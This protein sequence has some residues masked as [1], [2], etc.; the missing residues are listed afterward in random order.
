M[1]KDHRGFNLAGISPASKPTGG[2]IT[3][4]DWESSS[5][6]G[7][8]AAL[9]NRPHESIPFVWGRVGNLRRIGNPP[10][11]DMPMVL[12]VDESPSKR[13]D[14]RGRTDRIRNE[15]RPERCCQ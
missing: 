10:V 3:R 15:H 8:A 6:L 14:P 4:T 12:Y 5:Q 2:A 13:M 9:A 1:K 7:I 11:R